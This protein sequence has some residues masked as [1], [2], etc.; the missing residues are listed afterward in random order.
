MLNLNRVTL[1]GVDGANWKRT[2][3]ILQYCK[4]LAEFHEVLYFSNYE[5]PAEELQGIRYIKA[6]INSTVD[7]CQYLIREMP[8]YITSDFF[9][10]VQHDGFIVNPEA[11]TDQFYEYDYIGS[12]WTPGLLQNCGYTQF[13][14]CLNG[15]DGFSLRSTKLALAALNIPGGTFPAD[16]FVAI[17]HR[18]EL[19]NMGFKFAPLDVA[20]K[21]SVENHPYTNSFGCHGPHFIPFLNSKL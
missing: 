1:I 17:W 10:T 5:P 4:K 20:F 21:F 2:I 14:E 9:M 11:W 16:N 3:P 18:Q 15:G 6:N 8:L 12:P 13:T 19:E 7:Y